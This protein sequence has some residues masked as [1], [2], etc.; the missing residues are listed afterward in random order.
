[1]TETGAVL[2]A[3]GAT[4]PLAGALKPPGDKS[5]SHRALIFSTLAEGQ[6]RIRGLLQAK[7]VEATANACRQLGA[8]IRAEDDSIVVDGLGTAGLSAP[9]APLDMGNSGTAMRLLAG[10]LAAQPFDSV[11]VGDSS[12]QSRPM[13]RVAMPLTEMGARIRTRENGCAPLEISGGQALKGI[14]YQSPVASAQIKSCVLLAGLYASGETTVSEPS[15]SRDHTERMLQAFGVELPAPT[16]VRGGA[17]LQ[18]TEL[19]VPSDISSAAFFAVGATLVPCSDV[20]MEG[21]GI[22]PSRDGLVHALRRMDGNLELEN[23]RDWGA[24]PVA[25]LQVRHSGLLKAIDLPVE[26]VPS[27]IDELPIVMVAMAL[28]QGTSSIRGAA[29]LRHKE[30]DRIA[31]M[32][33]GLQQLGFEVEALEDGMIIHGRPSA[34]GAGGAAANVDAAGDHRCAMSF[35]ILAQVLEREVRISGATHIDTSYPGFVRD[36]QSLGGVAAA[37]GE[38]N[39]G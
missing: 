26:W 24:E 39:H 35:A 1:M 15:L 5:V 27:M 19:Q 10:V 22:N 9:A 18:A 14:H 37:E 17:R 28:A 4:S 23:R 8:R 21:V 13:R 6:S 25:D 32:E 12:L 2:V 7:D 34:I 30:S 20:R 38:P 16:T 31:V 33:A 29:E 3:R 36:L 11:L